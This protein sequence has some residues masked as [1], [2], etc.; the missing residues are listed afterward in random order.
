MSDDFK[1]YEK[2]SLAFQK[3][4]PNPG[5]IISV[6]FPDDIHPVQM[7][8]FAEGL[9]AHLP[10]DVVLLCLRAGTSIDKIP[11]TEMNK[12]GWYKFDMNAKP[13]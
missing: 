8:K 13:Q 3:L 6:R 12:H 2:A 5:D 1:V 10:E 4:E 7:E 9:R 11:E